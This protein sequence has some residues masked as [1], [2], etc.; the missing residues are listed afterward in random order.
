MTNNGT[1]HPASFP[2]PVWASEKPVGMLLPHFWRPPAPLVNAATAWT[3]STNQGLPTQTRQLELH[4]CHTTPPCH[5]P[6]S[7][8]WNPCPAQ[9]RS[10]S[11]RHS[12]KPPLPGAMALSAQPTKPPFSL[13]VKEA[14]G[15]SGKPL[16]ITPEARSW[17]QRNLGPKFAIAS[18]SPQ[19]TMPASALCATILSISSATT[20]AA[21]V[22]E[23]TEPSGT[24][25]SATSFLTYVAKPACALNWRSQACFYQLGQ[26]T[27]RQTAGL[28]T[29]T[30]HAGP[31]GCLLH[32]TSPLRHRSGRQSSG[33]QPA[34]HWLQQKL[35]CRLSATTLGPRKPAMPVASVS[36]QWCA[37]LL[38]LGPLKPWKSCS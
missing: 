23:G 36:S 38:G 13:S 6:T 24:I 33:R 21:A 8:E 17:P 27:L 25:P 3:P 26:R 15:N 16:P 9:S 18:A 5:S 30:S 22:L 34:P 32:L 28:L 1:R 4:L 2:W 35:T 11:P 31:E 14:P 10:F 19:T 12:I 29:S 37:T 7:L 20:A